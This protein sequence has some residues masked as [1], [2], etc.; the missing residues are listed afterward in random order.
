MTIVGGKIVFDG[1]GGELLS[2]EATIGD[3]IKL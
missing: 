2:T 1:S 3:M